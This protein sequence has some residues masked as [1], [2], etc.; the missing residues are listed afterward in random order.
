[1]RQEKRR[2]RRRKRR[3][4]AMW[5]IDTNAKLWNPG[6]SIS[7]PKTWVSMLEQKTRRNERRKERRKERRREERETFE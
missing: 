1:M 2:K 7:V 5:D 3:G 4:T 6:F